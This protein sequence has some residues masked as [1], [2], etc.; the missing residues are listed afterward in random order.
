MMP[1]FRPSRCRVFVAVAFSVA[2]H[3]LVS[4]SW[5]AVRDHAGVGTGAIGTQVDGPDDEETVFV[6]RDPP[7]PRPAITPPKAADVGPQRSEPVVLPPAVIAPT[8][9][10]PTANGVTQ[11]GD[12]TAN[13]ESLP[14]SGDGLPLHGKLKPGTSVVY[15][16]DCSS[17]MG[18][19]GRL[20]AAAASVKAS[21]PTLGTDVRFQLVAYNGGT[22][23]LGAELLHADPDNM[24]RAGRWLD[25]LEAEGR[26]DHRAGFRDALAFRPDVVYLLT[27]AD[28]FD[29]SETRAIRSLVRKPLMLNVVIVGGSRTRWESP[30]ERLAQDLGGSVKYL[31]R[32]VASGSGGR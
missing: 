7:R 11:T 21:L 13:A 3:G 25:A 9:P 18:P 4:L 10:G 26:S 5:L 29:Q 32:E 19:D 14:K 31:K 15:L 23:Q 1:T 20:Q 6:L 2:L 22:G 30:L 8:A 24:S 16:I 17:S 28:D 27:D 12:S